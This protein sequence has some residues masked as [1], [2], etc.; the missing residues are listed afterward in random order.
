MTR[1]EPRLLTEQGLEARLAAIAE[2][3]VEDLGFRLVRIKTNGNAGFTVQVMAE[4]EDGTFSVDDCE[5]VSKALAPVFDAED[6]IER[7][8]R[9]EISSPGIDRPLVRRSDFDRWKGH[10]CRIELERLYEGRKRL[11]GELLGLVRAD[12]GVARAQ[13]VDPDAVSPDT[14]NPDTTDDTDDVRVRVRLEGIKAGEPD[15]FDVPLGEIAE[16]KL[17]LTDALIEAS[18]RAGKLALRAELEGDESDDDADLDEADDVEADTAPVRSNGAGPGAPRA[19]GKPTPPGK[20]KAAAKK[21]PPPRQ[22]K[23]PQKK[24]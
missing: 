11:K 3:V 17:V 19:K 23:P 10:V 7:A 20:A 18:L 4:R 22:K 13:L 16:A 5:A 14:A 8:Y 15:T 21:P 2:P 6:P 24:K 12:G 1:F 9:L